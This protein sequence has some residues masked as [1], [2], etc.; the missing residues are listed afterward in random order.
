MAHK[1]LLKRLDELLELLDGQAGQV[2]DLVGFVSFSCV[3]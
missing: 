2:Q 3:A 1:R